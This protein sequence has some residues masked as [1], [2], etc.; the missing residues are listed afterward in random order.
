MPILRPRILRIVLAAALVAVL[1]LLAAACG[2]EPVTGGEP[3]GPA[4]ALQDDFLPVVPLDQIPHRLDLI[5]ETG[6]S[7]TRVDIFWWATAPEEPERPRDPRDPAYDW[8]RADAILSGLAERG[9]TPIVSVYSTPP[10]AAGGKGPEDPS[11]PV[12]T[13]PPDPEALAD[14]MYALAERYNGDFEDADGNTL[15]QQLH[16]EIWNE[17]NLGGFL[18]RPDPDDPE[19]VIDLYAE[20][21]KAAY[22]AI[23]EVNPNA[24]VIAGVAGPRGTTGPGGVGALPW[25]VGLKERHIPLDAYSQH[26]YPSAGPLVET[27]AIPSWSSIPRFLQELNGFKEGL[28]LYITEAGYTTQKTQYRDASATVTEAEQARYLSQMWN[29]P[30]VQTSRVQAIVW[31]NFQDNVNWPAGLLRAD[32]SRKPSYDAFRKIAQER[33]TATI[34]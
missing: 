25:L 17:P 3:V 33:A 1:A 30:Q 16:W 26:L 12:N 11:S 10:W 29:L 22:P 34:F 15:P 32:G 19:S 7:T 31:F 14:F 4:V 8:R 2:D 5:K 20:M 28:P 27:D 6:A 21:V 24:V 23:K 9:I 18:S 13:A